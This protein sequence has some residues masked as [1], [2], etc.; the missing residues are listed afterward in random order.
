MS[1]SCSLICYVADR[2]MLAVGGGPQFSMGGLKHSHWMAAGLLQ[3]KQS[4]RPRCE[5]RCLLRPNPKGHILFLSPL[6]YSVWE[7][8]IHKGMNT[9]RQELSGTIWKL[10]TTIP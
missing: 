7:G 10:A 1:A 4:R 6:L 8:T 5:P 2:V 3:S 9:R